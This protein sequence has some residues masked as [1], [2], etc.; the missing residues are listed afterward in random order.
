MKAILVAI[1]LCFAGALVGAPAHAQSQR[2]RIG[3][4]ATF[5]FARGSADFVVRADEPGAREIG[6]IAGWTV[7]NPDGLLVLDGHADRRGNAA[8]NIRLSLDRAK[9]VRNKLIEAGVDPAQIVIAAYGEK[10]A[11][12]NTRDRKVVVWGTRSGMAAVMQ[13]AKAKGRVVLTYLELDRRP[14]QVARQ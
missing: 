8:A 7:E 10:H 9:A 5:T 11:S 3:E 1:T 2:P 4:L 12:E 14:R 13:R 6:E